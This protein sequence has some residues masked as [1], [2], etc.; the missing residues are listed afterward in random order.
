MVAIVHALHLSGC[1]RRRIMPFAVLVALAVALRFSYVIARTRS[2]SRWLALP[3][4]V[5]DFLSASRSGRVV[6]SGI[7]YGQARD[8]RP[9]SDR[10]LGRATGPDAV[11]SRALSAASRS[12]GAPLALADQFERADHR[13]HLVVQERAR[14]RLD[15][16][17]VVALGRRPAG[18]ASAPG[19]SPGIRSSGSGEVMRADQPLGRAMHRD[20]I[21]PRA[22]VPD[23]AAVERPAARGG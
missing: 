12:S 17:L 20:R 16:E 9:A 6:R 8:S 4:V 5:L 23:A 22:T 1:C 10:A 14:R 19:F 11:R 21:E 15:D 7:A 2:P 18:R 13:A 3:I